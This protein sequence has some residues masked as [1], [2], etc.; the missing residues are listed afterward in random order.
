LRLYQT[1]HGAEA[2]AAL[3]K[4]EGSPAAA[5]AAWHDKGGTAVVTATELNGHPNAMRPEHGGTINAL[6]EALY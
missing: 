5:H 2:Y 1:L 3:L 4:G 6:L